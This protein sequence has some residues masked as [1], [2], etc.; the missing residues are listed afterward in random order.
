DVHEGDVLL[1][2]VRIAA[3]DATE[4]AIRDAVVAESG[5]VDAS[6]ASS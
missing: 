6:P 5:G 3:A 2:R 1:D 4:A